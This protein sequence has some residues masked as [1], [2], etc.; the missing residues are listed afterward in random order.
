MAFGTTFG[1]GG[2][3]TMAAAVGMALSAGLAAGRPPLP[4]GFIDQ[5]VVTN[6]E[7]LVG[8]GFAPLDLVG[9]GSTSG[10]MFAWERAARSG[11]SRTA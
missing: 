8:V 6:F 3:L 11:R 4:P 2:R 10:R 7:Q 9:D 1:R 5:V